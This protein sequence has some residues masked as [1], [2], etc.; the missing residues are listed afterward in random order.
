MLCW[1]CS[2]RGGQRCW[3]RQYSVEMACS[4]SAVSWLDICV[5]PLA[6]ARCMSLEYARKF[7]T[8][9]VQY[10]KP[11]QPNDAATVWRKFRRFARKHGLNDKHLI[12]FSECNYRLIEYRFNYR[13]YPIID[14]PASRGEVIECI[15]N[16]DFA[17]DNVVEIIP[18]TQ[19]PYKTR[20]Q[21]EHEKCAYLDDFRQ[22]KTFFAGRSADLHFADVTSKKA[23][24]S[25]ARTMS[26]VCQHIQRVVRQPISG[27]VANH[28][29]E[30]RSSLSGG[31]YARIL[32]IGRRGSGR[33]TQAALLAKRLGLV[34][35]RDYMRNLYQF[36]LSI[37]E[38][39]P[40]RS[41]RRLSG[42]AG[43]TITRQTVGRHSGRP[44]ETSQSMRRS[45]CC[46][47]GAEAHLAAGLSAQ[48]LRCGWLCDMRGGFA[49][50]GRALRGATE[51]VRTR[52]GIN[53]IRVYT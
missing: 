30:L 47:A 15:A 52:S 21:L 32:L 19:V 3:H 35:G 10:T 9:I 53:R 49:S 18:G 16:A 25:V 41:R 20:L 31:W 7:K 36:W 46:G 13:W 44:P 8:P 40:Q 28:R 45:V 27:N 37:H 48:W 12:A 50:D 33:K 43:N 38:M 51:S 2:A 17:P 24:C 42:A 29:F 14:F 6:D 23:Q 26:D 4:C 1:R 39:R 22:V 34:F 11:R 5:H